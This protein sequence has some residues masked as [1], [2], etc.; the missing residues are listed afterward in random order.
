MRTHH[1][2]GRVYRRCGCRDQQKHQLGTHCPLLNTD[3]KHGTWTF[4]VEIPAAQT[5]GHNRT[6]RRGGFPTQDDA[7]IALHRYP[8]GRSIGI[9]ADPNQTLE[10]HLIQ[11]LAA[12]KLRLKP[13]TWIRYRDYTRNDLIPALGAIRLDDLAYE[14]L[15]HFTQTQLAA[16]RGQQT[17]WHVLATLSSALGEAV[18]THRLPVNVARPTV[19]PRPAAAERTIWTTAQAVRFLHHCRR[20]DPDFAD[21]A[22][23]L[24][25]TGLRR[26]E[27]LAL[28]WNDVHLDQNRLYTRWTL[29]AVDNNKLVMTTP[30]TRASRDWVALSPRV[31]AV[32]ER[33][34]NT[35]LAEDPTDPEYG[36]GFVFA[37]PDGRAWH[38]EWVLNHFHDLTQQAGVPRC[39]LH[40]LRHLAV[41]IAISEN[42]SLWAVSQ[43]ARHSP[44]PPPRTSTPTS[45]DVPPTKPSTPSPPPSTAKKSVATTSRPPTLPRLDAITT[46]DRSDGTGDDHSTTTSRKA[47]PA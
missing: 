21:L 38:P 23:L 11:W 14:H 35:S 7:G 29:S 46:H 22:E 15:H 6:V 4:A 24:I 40:D 12:Q 27:A 3:P 47:A 36:N 41:T 39:T 45:P 16:G 31:S 25:D 44:S 26:G 13:T 32:L 30:K 28:H 42:V 2:T 33:R 9:S 17:V 34:R 37:R 1:A 19:I 8:A 20:R 18:R 10:D 5:G 43:T